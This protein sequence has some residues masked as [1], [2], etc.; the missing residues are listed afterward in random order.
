MYK[1]EERK[2]KRV[3]EK[4]RWQKKGMEVQ[5]RKTKQRGKKSCAFTCMLKA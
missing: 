2:R 5:E 1:K 4:N 3:K